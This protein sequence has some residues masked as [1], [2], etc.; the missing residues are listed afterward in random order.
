VLLVTAGL[1]LRSIERLFGVAPG[2]D[3]SQLLTM[4]VQES[5]HRFEDDAIKSQFFAQA[6]QSVLRVPGVKSAA[7][8]SL[9]PL[10]GD[11]DVYGVEFEND[12]N[13]N[14]NA[15]AFRYAVTPGYCEEMGIPLRHGRMLDEHDRAGAPVAVLISE[16]LA[17]RKFPGRDPLGQRLRMGPDIGRADRPW[18]TI[19]GVVGDVRQMSL[20]ASDSDAVYITTTQWSWV[21]NVQSLVVRAHGDAAALAPAIRNS[22]WSVDKDQPIVRVATMTALLAASAAQRR[23]SL[24]IFEAFAL[25][26]LV[27][28]AAGIYGVLSGS[29]TE[30]TREIGVRSALGATPASILAMVLRQG[31]TLTAV[32]IAIGLAGAIAA[33]QAIAAMLF[34]V[35]PLDPLTYLGV[36]TMLLGVSAIACWVP[37]SRAARVDPATTLRAE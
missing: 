23:F 32:G 17:K 37:A 20:A 9:L 5:G 7:F 2:F 26:A 16:S 35:S 4:Q 8:T 24:V 31:I 27:L 1:L 10:S 22:I 12:N 30:R 28:A 14:E 13:P 11:T 19:V 25:A 6:L 29:V 15:A 33:S 36:I 21:D 34:G 18:G 3:S